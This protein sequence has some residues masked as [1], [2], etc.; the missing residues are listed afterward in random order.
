MFDQLES[1]IGRYEELGELLSDP[2]VVANTKRFMELS[3][4][5]ANLRDTVATYQE[6]KKVL[7]QISE[8]EEMLN[9]GG[10][11]DEM[12]EL[13]KEELAQGKAQKPILEEQMKILLLP[14][15][16]NDGKNIILEVRGAAGGDEAALFAADLLNMYQHYSESQD[17]KFEVMEANQTSIGGF[18]EVS[19]LISGSSVYSKLKYESGAHRVQRVPV[20]E[21]QGRVHTS[22]ATV[23][24]MPEVEEFDYQIDPNEIRT[25][26][27]HASGAGGQ[28]V[29]KVA[30]AVRMVHLPTGIKVEMQEERTQQKNRDKA[31]KL[32]NTKVF[33]HYQ[34]IE[35]D[36]QNTERKSTVGTGDRSERIR[37]YN[38]PQN[39]V[40]DHRIGLTI[41][42]LDRIIS[43]EMDE[44]ID[45]LIIYDQ[46]KKLEALGQ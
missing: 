15:D 10:L 11:D 3:R 12:K 25:D 41:Q 9:E 44:I 39:R 31:I 38:F 6:Y 18:K 42:K 16:P 30:T 32:L 40:T 13:F 2:E 24:V 33:D 7:E 26:I 46:T 22:T 23:L 35:L 29:N 19:A 20:T 37:T 21:T 36:K 17:W 34:Q 28:N 1:M 45:S 27:Y 43:G 5:E 14:K 8:S 4:E